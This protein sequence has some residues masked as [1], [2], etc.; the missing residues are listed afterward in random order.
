M[1]DQEQ[2]DNG[3]AAGAPVAKLA[4][5][6]LLMVAGVTALLVVVAGKV[7]GFGGGGGSSAPPDTEVVEV[8]A[9]GTL[10][11]LDT[12]SMVLADGRLLRVRVVAEVAEYHPDTGGGGHGGGSDSVDPAVVR[13]RGVVLEVLGSRSAPELLDPAK[14]AEV[15]TE[16]RQRLETVFHSR[17]LNALFTEFLIQ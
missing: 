7:I 2:Q 15:A 16:L 11:D 8:P 13:A 12:Q 10:V 4:L 5:P 9:E 14:R 17:V 6:Q 3:A 1:A